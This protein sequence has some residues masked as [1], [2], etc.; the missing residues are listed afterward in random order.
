MRKGIGHH[1][2]I[3][4]SVVPIFFPFLKDYIFYNRIGFIIK[5]KK[6]VAK[7]FGL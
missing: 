6:Y 1:L 4:P 5:I 3:Y 7:V 2:G